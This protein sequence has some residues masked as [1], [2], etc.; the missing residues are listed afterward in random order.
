M[1]VRWSN[2]SS[3]ESSFVTPFLI[4]ELRHRNTVRREGSCCGFE[5]AHLRA[6][7]EFL[8]G[9]AGL[10]SL[11]L[12]EDLILDLLGPTKHE[13]VWGEVQWEPPFR[14]DRNSATAGVVVP[15]VSANCGMCHL[16]FGDDFSTDW[17]FQMMLERSRP[18]L[19]A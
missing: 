5:N 8:L 4:C 15:R 17:K 6:E 7:D 18:G 16:Y 10:R 2:L 9:E 19:V 3:A 1:V 11:D 13:I 14:F 12:R